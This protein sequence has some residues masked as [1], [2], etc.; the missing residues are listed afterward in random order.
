VKNGGPEGREKNVENPSRAAKKTKMR[1]PGRKKCNRNNFAKKKT[2]SKNVQP[3]FFN[4]FC[5][6]G[7][8]V[9]QLF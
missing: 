2:F 9:A 8:A 5:C 4:A 6:Y 3:P 1:N 7:D